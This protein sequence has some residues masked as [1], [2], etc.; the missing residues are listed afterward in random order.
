MT[1][2]TPDISVLAF[3]M[4]THHKIDVSITALQRK[5]CTNTGRMASAHFSTSSPCTHITWKTNPKT[6]ISEE[7]CAVS[8]KARNL[9]PSTG[10]PGHLTLVLGCRTASVK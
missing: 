5:D 3:L 10:C 1:L 2:N 4:Q 8:S 7:L 9:I 6:C